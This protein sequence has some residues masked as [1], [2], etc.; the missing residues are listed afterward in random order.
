MEDVMYMKKALE[1]AQ[2]GR[3]F[4]NPNPMVGAVIVKNDKIIGSGYHKKY[5]GPHAEVEAFKSCRQSPQGATMYV[6]LEP[7]C[8]YGSTPPCT[9]AI[10]KNKIKKVIIGSRDPNPLVSGGG[11]KEL[12]E[13]GIE[14]KVGVS[15]RECNEQNE[16]FRHYII[17]KTPFVTMK[18]AMT[19]DGKIATYTGLSKWI[20]GEK[21]REQVHLDRHYNS[22]IMV[23]VGTVISDDPQLTSRIED[24]K[25]PI[26]IICDTSLRTPISSYLVQNASTL[27]TI[28]A[29]AS[30]D[31]SKISDF[32]KYSCTILKL[33]VRD[34]HIN[35]NELMKTLARWKID[36]ILLEG[37]GQ[38]NWSALNSGIVQK[39]HTYIAPKIF[40]GTAK[41]PVEGEGVS[42]PDNAFIL[43]HKRIIKLDNDILIESDVI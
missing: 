3:G 25:N 34:K 31:T 15:E 1:L 18:Y 24:T 36:S 33:K 40:G 35:L 19:M 22:A 30:D 28:I 23:G 9:K 38:L 27:G 16:I 12:R 11:I 5:G 20:T 29:T 13:N 41:S 17:N 43:K 10:I 37:G 14:V 39:V 21:A 7:C 4:V 6:T 42:S 32:E 2:K 26:P 8:H